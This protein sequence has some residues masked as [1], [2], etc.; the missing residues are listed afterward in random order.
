MNRLREILHMSRLG[1]ST[2]GFK[3]DNDVNGKVSSIYE[4]ILF[5]V[6]IFTLLPAEYQDICNFINSPV[7]RI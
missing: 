6:D 3:I 2:N 7:R 4:E 5:V 1:S